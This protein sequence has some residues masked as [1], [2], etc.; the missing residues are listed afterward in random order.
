MADYKIEMR[1]F[2]TN[3]VL[4]EY[5]TVH[6]SAEEMDRDVGESGPGFESHV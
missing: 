4:P 3:C 6:S 2:Q 5:A 1:R